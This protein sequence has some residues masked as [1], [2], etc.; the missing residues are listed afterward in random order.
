MP[1]RIRN[2]NL[3]WTGIFASRVAKGEISM[4]Q[5]QEEER[6]IGI[7]IERLKDFENHP[8]K[9]KSDQEMSQFLLIPYS[10]P[11]F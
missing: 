8:F 9:V 11:F 2:K 5:K 3:V 1:V 4:E 10:I 7:E 6:I